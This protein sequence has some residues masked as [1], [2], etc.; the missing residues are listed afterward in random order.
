MDL[1]TYFRFV[2]AL[3]LV[4]G[5]IGTIAWALKRFGLGQAMA[6]RRT[7]G[8]ERR[9]GI[10]ESMPLDAKRRLVLV[11]RDGVEHLLLTGVGADIVIETGIA[12]RPSTEQ[13]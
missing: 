7:A 13:S 6:S 12:P 4:L 1:D 5:L 2:L 9:L 10:V 3:G 8:A 11:R